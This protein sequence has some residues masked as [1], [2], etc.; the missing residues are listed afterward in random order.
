MWNEFTA[1]RGN[2][3]HSRGFGAGQSSE[4]QVKEAQAC[5]WNFIPE[6]APGQSTQVRSS[7]E[8]SLGSGSLGQCLDHGRCQPLCPML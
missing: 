7:P 8:G 3:F 2:G 1:L 6:T 5:K 4:G